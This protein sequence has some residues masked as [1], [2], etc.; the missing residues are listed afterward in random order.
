MSAFRRWAFDPVDAAPMAALRIACGLLVLGWTFSLLP[1]LHA[2][3]DD[4]GLT[5]Q[6]VD[7]TRGWW[8]LDLVSPYGALLLLG[9][10]GVAL[11]LGWHTRIAA[12]VVAVLLIV[13]QRR[14][15][16]VLNSGD[17]L[18]RE[19]AFYVALMPAG[20]VWSLD[21]RRRGTSSPRAPWG[22][23]I[24]Q[25]QV[26]MVYLFSVAAKLH[27]DT[28]QDGT[29]VGRAVQL[30]DLQRFVVPE[31]VA[32]SVTMSALMT[33]GT[34]LVEGTLVFGLWLPRFRW[35]VMAAGV[36][37]HLGIEATLLIGW[38]SLA[39]I[40]CYL[41]FVPADV[42]RTAVSWVQR[43]VRPAPPSPAP[44][45]GLVA[46]GQQQGSQPG[47]SLEVGFPS[48]QGI[49]VDEGLRQPDDG[50][51]DLVDRHGQGE[52]GGMVDEELLDP[53]HHEG[54]HAAPVVGE[55]AQGALGIG[56]NGPPQPWVVDD[57]PG[58]AG[59]DGEAAGPPASP[60]SVP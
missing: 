58:V 7:G 45:S 11:L 4:D 55:Q 32:T 20:E 22:L 30:A 8:T 28:W 31:G 35:F 19:M 29:A 41:A 46:G 18:L 50:I 52:V 43:R 56:L 38:F 44:T 57:E 51:G 14:D 12:V 25:L 37:I 2:F 17:L 23:R 5:A 15:V 33:Y 27:G 10:A 36:S 1:D 16:Y 53:V 59:E 40:S 24:L 13:V 60:P 49:G 34:L 6:A 47:Q 21:A 42:L 3:L 26:S 9:L 39:V 48:G 54:L